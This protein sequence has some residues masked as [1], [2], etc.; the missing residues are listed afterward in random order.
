MS[1]DN[2]K[3][4]GG[5]ERYGNADDADID[6]LME[7]VLSHSTNKFITYAVKMFYDYCN[8]KRYD[9][10][11]EGKTITVLNNL[12]KEFYVSVRRAKGIIYLASVL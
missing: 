2:S 10:E 1:E 5:C 12:L 9:P 7:G 4:A 8:S 11:F 6:E 3:A